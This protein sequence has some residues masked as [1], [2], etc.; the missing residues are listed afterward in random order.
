MRWVTAD[1]VIAIKRLP[2]ILDVTVHPPGGDVDTENLYVDVVGPENGLW[3]KGFDP[4][5]DVYPGRN[6]ALCDVPM[7]ELSDGTDSRGGLNSDSE[8]MA[9]AFVRIRKYLTRRG[10]EVVDSLDPYF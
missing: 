7:A 9:L 10:L 4:E 3:V 1:I 2:D 8:E 6:P 5:T